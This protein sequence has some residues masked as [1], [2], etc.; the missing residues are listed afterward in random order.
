ML[1]CE[2]FY[3]N[4]N[5]E[6]CDYPVGDNMPDALRLA[7]Q[8]VA[9]IKKA[10][11]EDDIIV[12]IGRGSSGLILCTFIASLMPITKVIHIKKEGEQSHST[13]STSV[14]NPQD[15]SIKYI[16]VDDFASTGTTIKE[17]IKWWEDML[18]CFNIKKI[19][20]LCIAATVNN[21][22]SGVANYNFDFIICKY[23]DKTDYIK[24][25]YFK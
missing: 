6:R 4:S 7:K 1:T 18:P 14:P 12:L 9:G 3:C 5:M 22:S 20:G 17:C 13:Q 21:L 15:K 23:M 24:K 11:K 25:I 19:N 10:T 8:M 16:L 2:R